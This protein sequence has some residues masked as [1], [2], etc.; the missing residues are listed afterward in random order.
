MTL[1]LQNL[2]SGLSAGSVYA[3]LAVGLVLIYKS[4]EVLNFAHGSF[5]MFATFVAYHL[6]VTSGWP[7]PAVTGIGYCVRS[8]WMT[9]VVKR[10]RSSTRRG[11]CTP[12]TGTTL[13]W[14]GG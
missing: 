9:G 13:Y 5:A 10:G 12:G 14:S 3:L 7:L 6:A 4:S 1:F 2:I 11:A 8:C